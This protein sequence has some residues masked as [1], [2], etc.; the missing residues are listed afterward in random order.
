MQF[1]F[2]GLIDIGLN[3]NDWLAVIGIPHDLAETQAM[4]CTNELGAAQK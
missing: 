3:K 1:T 2:Y 4:T